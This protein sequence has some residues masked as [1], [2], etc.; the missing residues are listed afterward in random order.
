VYATIGKYIQD[1]APSAKVRVVVDSSM[2]LFG[3]KWRE[4]MQDDPWGIRVRLC[5][6]VGV[7]ERVC[8]LLVLV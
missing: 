2:A 3:P 4:V 6:C 1:R 5:V 7:L 8:C